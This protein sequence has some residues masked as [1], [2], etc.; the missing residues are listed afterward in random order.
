[1]KKIIVLAAAAISAMA[2]AIALAAPAAQTLTLEGRVPVVCRA[3]YDAAV[4]L[5]QDGV[6]ELGRVREFCNAARG[7]SVVVEHSGA[8]D[9]GSIIVDG[10]EIP[11]S[12]SGATTIANVAGPAIQQRQIAY[13]PGE[14]SLTA[15][16][17]SVKVNWA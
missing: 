16:R 11:L 14:D 1:M 3:T 5:Y 10:R 15:L 13:R 2:P 9:V 12:S 4:G 8:G 7:Y 17:I 6:V